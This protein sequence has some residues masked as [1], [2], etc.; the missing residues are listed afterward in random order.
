MVG[1]TSVPGK[2][3]W[4]PTVSFPLGHLPDDRV[5]TV[6]EVTEVNE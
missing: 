4:R 5:D 3:T 2:A 1:H 6:Y